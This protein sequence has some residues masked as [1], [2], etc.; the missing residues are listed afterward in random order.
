MPALT[1]LAPGHR[2][3]CFAASPRGAARAAPKTAPAAL[4]ERDLLAVETVTKTYSHRR[5]VRRASIFDAVDD[6]SFALPDGRPEIFT[7]IGESGSG[8]T[9]LAR[10]ILNLVAADARA[11]SASAA[12]DVAAIRGSRRAHAPSWR[13][14]SR[15]S[16]T[17][18]RPSTR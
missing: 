4:H 1:T 7:I 15:S 18:S 6:V 11:R 2:V 3:A 13:R 17:R 12:R 10:M 5:A 14:C 8:K 16:R 9:T